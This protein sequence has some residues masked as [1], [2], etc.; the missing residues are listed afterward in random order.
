MSDP[1]ASMIEATG[2]VLDTTVVAKWYFQDEALVSDAL[3]V[4]DEFV[5]GKIRIIAPTQITHE[6]ASALLRATWPS[7]P[8]VRLDA[9]QAEAFLT[10]FQSFQI[11]FL[12][13][14]SLIPSA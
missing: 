14:E 12:Q 9:A 2:Y 3:Q 10:D 13:A 8:R 1:P 7:A 6:L 11:E 5:D 4:R